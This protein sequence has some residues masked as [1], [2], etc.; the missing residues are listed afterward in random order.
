MANLKIE[1]PGKVILGVIGVV[2]IFFVLRY[3]SSRPK[4][5][6]EAQVVGKIT[7]PDTKEASLSGTAAIKLEFPSKSPSSTFTVK[8][9]MQDMVWQAQ[10]SALYAN[11]GVFT[12]KGSLI[13]K[14]GW[15]IEISKQNDCSQTVKDYVKW[16]HDY[17]NGTTKD[18]FIGTFMAT[19]MPNYLTG[20]IEATKDLGPEYA[21]VIPFVYGKSAGEDQAIGPKEIKSNPQLLRG[22]VVHGVKLDGDM[23]VIIK[24]ANDNNVPFNPNPK[25]YY[26]DAL[27]ASYSDDYLKAVDEFN[28]NKPQYRTRV[29]NGKTT[30]KIDTVNID[31]VVT[32]TPGDKRA[33][34]GPRGSGLATLIST[35][36]YSS[37]MA[38][39]AFTSKKFVSDHR[40]AVIDL[41]GALAQAGDQIRTFDDVR[42]YVS[43][44]SVD[45]WGEQNAKYWYDNFK[46]LRVGDMKLGGSMVFNLADMAEMLGLNGGVDIYKEVYTTFGQKQSQYYPTELPKFVEYSKVIDKSITRS[47]MDNHPELLE[48]K[49]LTTDY[50]KNMTVQIASKSYNIQYDLGSDVI[51]GSSFKSLD[52]I[53][54]QVVTSDGLKIGV[55]G[56][57]DNSGSDEINIPLSEK[58]AQSVVNYL[59][60]KG[61]KPERFDVQGFG[62]TKP[63]SGTSPEDSKNRCVEIALLGDN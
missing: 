40:E 45:I 51:K 50:T 15:N 11:G 46:G 20:I 29:V 34:D 4:T 62:S 39:V 7:I 23:D 2:L 56:H 55:Y 3:V 54:S 27:N 38:A 52:E 42:Q 26:P 14:A 32:W 36:D 5:V 47:V 63:L 8:A 33:L 53:Y 37:M 6:G 16:V 30:N 44:L 60:K 59:K 61:L 1:G 24:Y 31:I 58:R 57:T 22:K 21:P 49:A 13:E 43:K 41:V 17:K 18:G 25:L 35:K 19:G 9:R 28:A 48:G 12:T 10:N